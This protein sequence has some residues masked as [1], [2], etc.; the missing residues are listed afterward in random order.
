MSWKIEAK[1]P[2]SCGSIVL[3]HGFGAN[4]EDLK[5]LAEAWI[6]VLPEW[7]Y[8]GI[9]API[10]LMDGGFSWF[11][12]YSE[13][14]QNDILNSSKWLELR[15]ENLQKPLIFVGFS[16]GAFISAHMALYSNLDVR[17]AICFS[18]GILPQPLEAKTANIFLIHGTDDSIILPDW[19]HKS[20][21][22]GQTLHSHTCNSCG[23]TV[24][25]ILIT[26]MQHEI[27]AEAFDQAT[28]KLLQMTS[29]NELKN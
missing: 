26:G 27:N 2:E 12:L 20:L 16:Q 1:I 8:L 18:G 22:F 15:L 9:D 7:D 3:L 14:W 11:D 5:D 25:G 23:N 13:N 6:N 17:G 24:D 4:S 10:P 29:N 21:E 19:F 28:Q